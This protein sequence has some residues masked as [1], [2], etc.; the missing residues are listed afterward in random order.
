MDQLYQR[1]TDCAEQIS[2]IKNRQARK[3]LLKMLK[4][5]DSVLTQMDMESVECR[6]T[7]RVTPRYQQLETQTRDLISNLEQHLTL[8]RLLYT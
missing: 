1:I 6:R 5:V 4:T 3:D 7:G 2:N 8:A